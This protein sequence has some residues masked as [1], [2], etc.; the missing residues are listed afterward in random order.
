MKITTW[1]QK[2]MSKK[3]GL[4][5]VSGPF[6]DLQINNLKVSALDLVPKETEGKFPFIHLLLYPK[7]K[8]NSEQ[9]NFSTIDLQTLK[10]KY[11]YF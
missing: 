4:N 5:Q 6:N 2:K 3:L 7:K 9:L 8:F 11:S 1:I 10:K